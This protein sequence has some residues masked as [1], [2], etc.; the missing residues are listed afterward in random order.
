M[1]FSINRESLWICLGCQVVDNVYFNYY[2]FLVVYQIEGCQNWENERPTIVKYF[3]GQSWHP[4]LLYKTRTF[5]LLYIIW[6]INRKSIPI[7]AKIAVFASYFTNHTKAEYSHVK[8]SGFD[9]SLINLDITS[10]YYICIHVYNISH[11]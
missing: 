4:E 9:T 11:Q 5:F 7:S 2:F 8:H 1:T 3:P 10:I 6:L